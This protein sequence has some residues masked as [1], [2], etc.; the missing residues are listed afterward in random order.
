MQQSLGVTTCIIV[1]SYM[2]LACNQTAETKGAVFKRKASY[3][4]LN[5]GGS[6]LNRQKVG[7][8]LG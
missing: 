4:C 6:S 2:N 5:H 3:S 1:V 7:T 8:W